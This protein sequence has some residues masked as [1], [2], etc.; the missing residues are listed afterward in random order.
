MYSTKLLPALLTAA[1]LAAAAGAQILPPIP[2]AAPAT[3]PYTPPPPPP[4]PPAP[5]ARP[6]PRPADDKPL[7][8]LI[9]RDAAGKLKRYDTS[10]EEAAL[11][12]ME[13]TDEQQA[14]IQAALDARRADIDK[15]V[16]EKLED[17]LEA[18]R[19]AGTI[20][21]LR[22]INELAKVKDMIVAISPERVLDRLL[23]EGA[24]T[25]VI[26]ARVEQVV[27]AYTDA[28]TTERQAESGSDFMKIAQFVAGDV[29]RNGTR[30]AFASL[31]SM[32]VR[33]AKSI[34]ARGEALALSGP[35]AAAYADLKR[36]AAPLDPST[37]EGLKKRTELT[38]AF[39]FDKLD[40]TA[41][42]ALLQQVAAEE[43]R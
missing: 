21:Q 18:R 40:I 24:I 12:R 5:P 10:L 8:T 35:A 30:D 6:E 4:P 32:L 22:D 41:Q 23:R 38:R 37:P 7:P 11:A 43:K 42:R 13:F 17:V 15:L 33:A 16:I 9:E 34:E 36:A 3:P 25:P 29:F 28:L 2:P 1:S 26:K 39:F 19:A 27:R 20:D 31:D 14:R